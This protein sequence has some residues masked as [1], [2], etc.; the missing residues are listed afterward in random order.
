MLATW[1]RDNNSFKWSIGCK[2][3]Q[4][5]KNNSHRSANKCS[6]YKATFGIETPMGLQS[7][8]IPREK[9]SELRTAKELFYICGIGYEGDYDFLQFEDE[10]DFSTFST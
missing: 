4:L 2:F 7:T 1:M 3:I 10:D 9:W 5:Q 8:T 6:T